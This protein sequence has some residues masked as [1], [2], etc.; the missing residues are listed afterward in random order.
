MLCA[1]GRSRSRRCT[2][3]A[4]RRIGAGLAGAVVCVAIAACGSSAP[5]KKIDTAALERSIAKSILVE[6]HLSTKVSCPAKVSE[7]KG[8]NFNCYALLQVGRYRVP[9]TQVNGHGGV[10]WHARQ[11]IVLLNIGRV[12]QAIE[13]SIVKQR[14]VRA[15]VRCPGRVL[16]ARGI[17]F[18][19]V[20][21]THGGTKVHAGSY[22]FRVTETNGAGR[23]AYIEG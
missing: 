2:R 17:R 18:T 7:Q 1:Y 21:T 3:R 19:C 4:A 11:P 9:V 23:V 13:A 12:K 15:K 20:A 6:H 16:Q 14:K 10:S 5:T 22:P 8:A